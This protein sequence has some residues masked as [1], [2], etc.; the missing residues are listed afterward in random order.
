[1]SVK[2][3]IEKLLKDMK[4]EYEWDE[5]TSR[6]LLK[7]RIAGKYLYAFV[8]I[9]KK[10]IVTSIPLIRISELEDKVNLKDFYETILKE[11][12]YLKEVNYGLTEEGVLVSHAETAIEAFNP[13]DF[14]VELSSAI[15]GF[16][17]FFE[18]ILP[19]FI[20]K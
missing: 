7:F 17:Y 9:G 18:T 13:N 19:R 3:D 15:L 2:D 1:M 8:I 4:L 16:R 10:W 5:K 12:F 6:F 20:N 11:T 14:K